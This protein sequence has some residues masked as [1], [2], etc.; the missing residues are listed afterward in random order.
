[1]FESYLPG[2]APSNNQDKPQP[3]IESPVNKSILSNSSQI[4]ITKKIN[5]EAKIRRKNEQL[6]KINKNY[7]FNQNMNGSQ[8]SRDS[9]PSQHTLGSNDSANFPQINAGLLHA[10]YGQ[11][12]PPQ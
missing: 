9:V 7:R 8:L 4:S 10:N 3:K 6:K 2:K 11:N 12:Q 1:M 5:E